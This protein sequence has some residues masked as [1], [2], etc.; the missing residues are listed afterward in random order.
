M[1]LRIT[2]LSQNK[3]NYSMNIQMKDLK[4]KTDLDKNVNGNDLI[5]R[6]KGD[7]ADLKFC[8]FDNVFDIFDK[9]RDGKQIYPM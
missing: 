6:Y 4:K 9:I 1:M 8:E 2:H 7:T 5:Y 3:K